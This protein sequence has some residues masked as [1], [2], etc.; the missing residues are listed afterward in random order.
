MTTI[1]SICRKHFLVLSSFMAYHLVCSY[2]NRTGDISG[3]ELLILP[4]HLSS[5]PVLVRF[6]L[7]DLYVYV[8][9]SFSTFFSSLC[10]TSFFELRILITPLV[11]SNFTYHNL[12]K[13]FP[14]HMYGIP[15]SLF[16]SAFASCSSIV[17]R[18]PVSVSFLYFILIFWINCPKCNQTD[19]C[20]YYK[21][22]TFIK[23]FALLYFKI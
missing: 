21:Y 9:L 17:Y 7:L 11:S 14:W 5:P 19:G 15:Y 13:R 1:C 12:A 16:F 6:V 10:C 18:P 4:K 8:Y 2:T 3:A 20:R 23:W 22:I